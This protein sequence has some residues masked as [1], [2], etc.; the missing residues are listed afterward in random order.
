MDKESNGGGLPAVFVA[1]VVC[2]GG[3]F[4]VATGALSVFG[5]WL[6][7]VGLTWLLMAAVLGI[8]GGLLLRRRMETCA[9]LLAQRT[10]GCR[11]PS[12]GM[13]RIPSGNMIVA[14]ANAV[15][16]LAR[17]PYPA[18]QFDDL[19]PVPYAT[20]STTKRGARGT[21]AAAS[22]ITSA[23]AAGRWACWLRCRRQSGR[24]GQI[25]NTCNS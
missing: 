10:M 5:A 9:W 7:E 17:L 25:S 14:V 8:M 1:H 16:G 15:G 22:R 3:L 13:L 23:P 24:R 20:D 18:A 6:V 19:A 11:L 21:M 4:L 12:C 2:C